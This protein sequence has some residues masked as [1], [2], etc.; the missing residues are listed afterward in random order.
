[1]WFITF[2]V[3]LALPVR[4]FAFVIFMFL[5]VA[6]SFSRREVILAF[7]VKL[8]WWCWTL[9]AFA[10]LSNFWSL[11]QTWMKSFRVEYSWLQVFLF[12]HFKYILPP[13]LHV[14]SAKKLANRLIGVPIY[15]T[16]CLSRIDY[17]FLYLQFL[18]F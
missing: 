3:Y 4:F 12:N 15:V 5:V 14:V 16:H 18:P 6:F 17:I 1:M 13:L 9:V 10:Y 2:P 11:H 8:V 7:L